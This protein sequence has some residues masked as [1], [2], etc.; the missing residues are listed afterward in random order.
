MPSLHY[1]RHWDKIF[2]T[3]FVLLGLSVIIGGIVSLIPFEFVVLL[4]VFIIIIGAGKLAEEISKR[5]LFNYQ[6]D[7]YK[8][9]YQLSQHL[10]KTFSIASMN[11]EK[12]EFRIQ[13][14][15]QKRSEFEKLMN[16]RYRD[17]ARKIIELENKV[18]KLAKTVERKK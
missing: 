6:D 18:N 12:N 3:F 15:D 10:D 8:K 4:G 11:R 16:K 17:I 9:M 14:L 2:W 1:F 7:I 13:K 5:K